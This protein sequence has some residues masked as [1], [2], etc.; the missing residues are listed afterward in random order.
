M[1]VHIFTNS[2]ERQFKYESE[3][4]KEVL[5]WYD[6]LDEGSKWDGWIQYKGNWSHVSDY[7][8]V[9]NAVHNPNPPEWIQ[10]WDG[11]TNDCMSTGTLIKIVDDGETYRIGYFVTGD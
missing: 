1:G 7:L 9:R 4:P 8:A 5:E 6:W 10:K 11:Y 2:H 3:V